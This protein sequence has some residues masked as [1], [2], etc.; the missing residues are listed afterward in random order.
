MAFLKKEGSP[1]ASSKA[2]PMEDDRVLDDFFKPIVE[3]ETVNNLFAAIQGRPKVGKSTFCLS[4]VAATDGPVY[5]LDT[6]GAIRLNSQSLPREQRERIFVAEVLQ[7]AGKSNNKVNLVESLDAL[8]AAVNKISDAALAEPE[9]KGT[10]IVDSATDIWDWLGIWLDEAAEVK[11][12]KT[13]AMPRFEWGKANEKYAEI[14]YMLK[15][16]N[17]N[18]L[19][20]YRSKEACNSD[21]TPLGFDIPRWQKN[22]AHWVDLIM[23]MKN[24]DKRY[25]RFHGGR[26]GDKLPDLMDPTVA[27]LIKLLEKESGVK[28]A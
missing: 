24:E 16:T 13:G 9:I 28:F 27:R 2:V 1:A 25:I 5:V 17:W 21:G 15:R 6:E 19:M 11:R 10:I 20:T 18:V 22:T 26:F 14:M 7:F 23:E 3:L 8:I 4:A 12:T